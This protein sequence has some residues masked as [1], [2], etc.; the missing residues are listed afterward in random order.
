MAAEHR[1]RLSADVRAGLLA[2]YDSWAHRVAVQR[3]VE[4]IPM[5]ARHA[6]YDTLLSIE[7]G[8]AQL[9]DHPTLLAWGMRDWCFTPQ[10]LRRFQEFFPQA[11]VERYDDAGHYVIEDAHERIIPRLERFLVEHPLKSAHGAVT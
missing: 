7:Q 3:F 11:E 9:S 10:F 8:L 4:D 5:N 2:P 1:E 6:S